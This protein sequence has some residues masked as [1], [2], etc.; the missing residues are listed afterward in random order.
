MLK[1]APM[2]VEFKKYPGVIPTRVVS[3]EISGGK[4]PEIYSSLSENSGNLLS[5][6]T[7]VNRSFQVQHCKVML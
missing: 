7:Y 3:S 1:S 6:P 4:F 2:D 5:R